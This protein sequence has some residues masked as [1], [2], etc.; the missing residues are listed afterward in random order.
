MSLI[1]IA[2]MFFFPPQEQGQSWH[3]EKPKSK[4]KRTLTHSFCPSSASHSFI[5]S[6]LYMSAANSCMVWILHGTKNCFFFPLSPVYIL[7]TTLKKEALQ[8]ERLRKQ[9]GK[10]WINNNIGLPVCGAAS[11][12]TL[13]LLVSWRSASARVCV[14]WTLKNKHFILFRQEDE[15]RSK[16]KKVHL[17]VNSQA[18][19]FLALTS[20]FGGKI[21]KVKKTDR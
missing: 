15:R 10:R 3:D 1:C 11:T 16:E 17:L 20:A 9:K 14:A 7:R 21:G 19:F 4:K 13:S 6:P 12:W 8:H 5:T 18:F 2:L